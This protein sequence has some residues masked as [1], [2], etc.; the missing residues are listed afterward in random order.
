MVVKLKHYQRLSLIYVENSKISS[1]QYTKA[2]KRRLPGHE[3]K[4]VGLLFQQKPK[5]STC[6]DIRK[7]E[8]AEL[9]ISSEIPERPNLAQTSFNSTKNLWDCCWL[10]HHIF[11]TFN[12]HNLLLLSCIK[13]R[14][15]TDCHQWEW[16]RI[17]SK[18][19][20]NIC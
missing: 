5:C 15:F 20:K 10:Y 2:F 12:S 7:Q 19:I 8:P 11:S 13:F 16:F 14:H 1:T 17:Q 4:S 6:L 18:W 9:I 3:I